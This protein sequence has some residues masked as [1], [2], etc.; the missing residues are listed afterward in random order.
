MGLNILVAVWNSFVASE[1]SMT[2]G[3]FSRSKVLLRRLALQK[4]MSDCTP[5]SLV[6]LIIMP[7]ILL[8]SS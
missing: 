7:N 5:R 4:M 6:K 2:F 3:D 1:V 8:W